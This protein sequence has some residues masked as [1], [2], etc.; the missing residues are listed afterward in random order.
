MNLF[1]RA[2]HLGHYI[3]PEGGTCL[4]FGVFTGETYCYQAEQM[5]QQYEASRLIGFDSWQGLPDETEG[6]WAPDRHQPGEFSA[7]K[8]EVLDKL[9]KLG[10]EAGGD[11]FQL[12]D[13]FF[14]ES[15]TNDLRRGIGDLIFVN[16][17]VDIYKSTIELLDFVGP[18]LRPGV[19][20]Y[21]DDWKDPKDQHAEDWG[22]HLAW[23]HWLQ[24][25]DWLRVETLEVNPVNQRTM[26]VTE[27]TGSRLSSP[28]P[29]MCDIRY[30]LA[31]LDPAPREV[32]PDYEVFQKLKGRMRRI[33]GIRLLARAIRPVLK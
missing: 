19:I 26:I 21:W 32:D 7:P 6:V 10:A 25:Q 8:A 30:H 27:V 20:L 13:G 23:E 11:R 9:D 16:I 12:I 2:F 28:L 29:S 17:D 24:K 5:L 1:Q 31:G 18:I 14:S 33:P 3:F 4:E 15:L 22:E